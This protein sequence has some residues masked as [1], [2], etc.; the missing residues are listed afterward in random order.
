MA[1]LTENEMAVR[2]EARRRDGY[3][4]YDFRAD[5]CTECGRVPVDGGGVYKDTAKKWR[6]MCHD[7]GGKMDCETGKTQT[8]N[9]NNGGLV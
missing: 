2:N 3:P 9:N 1:Y 5:A 8:Q 7:C 4:P 6:R